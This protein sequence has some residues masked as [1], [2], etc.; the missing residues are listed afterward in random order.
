MV[1]IAFAGIFSNSTKSIHGAPKTVF[2]RLGPVPQTSQTARVVLASTKIELKEALSVSHARPAIP[3][4][5]G[6][7]A[8]KEAKPT[9][10]PAPA[11]LVS[12]EMA[13]QMAW[14]A[15]YAPLESINK[16]PSV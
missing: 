13:N 3:T 6:P 8:I 2:L 7:S 14:D 11:N 12:L 5:L 15:A 1:L 10:R 16:D 4:R 9:T